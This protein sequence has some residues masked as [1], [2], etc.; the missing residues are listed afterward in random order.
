MKGEPSLLLW[1]SVAL[2]LKKKPESQKKKWGF[3]FQR[4]SGNTVKG[5][6][7]NAIIEKP[8][9]QERAWGRAIHGGFKRCHWGKKEGQPT[10]KTEVE[11]LRIALVPMKI[12]WGPRERF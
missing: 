4:I 1:G 5:T 11:E 3:F 9:F 2:S 10:F 8:L 7:K 6:D 12:Q